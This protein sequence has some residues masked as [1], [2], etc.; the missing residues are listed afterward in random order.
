MDNDAEEETRRRA[1]AIW[2]SEGRPNGRREEHWRRARGEMHGLEDAPASAR[3]PAHLA[4][5][6]GGTEGS[7]S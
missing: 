2:E 7:G 4:P 3:R 5:A 1:Y 6:F